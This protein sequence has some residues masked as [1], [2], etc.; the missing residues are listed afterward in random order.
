MEIYLGIP[1]AERRGWPG[2]HSVTISRNGGPGWADLELTGTGWAYTIGA[3]PWQLVTL[4]CWLV[5]YRAR[6]ALRVASLRI[7][8][9]LRRLT[10]GRH[11]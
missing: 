3:S 10:H 6:F 11:A 8:Y 4:A 1:I 9:F 2:Q 7:M 5:G